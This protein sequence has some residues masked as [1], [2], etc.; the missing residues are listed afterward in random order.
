MTKNK[1]LKYLFSLEFG[2]NKRQIIMMG[3]FVLICLGFSA[4]TGGTFIT[5]RNLSNLSLQASATG[6]AAIGVVW[7]LVSGQIDLSIGSFIGFMGA[8]AAMLMVNHGWGSVETIAVVLAAGALLGAWQG[9]W[10]AYRRIP[11]FIVTLAGMQMFRGGCLM[12]TGGVTLSPMAN[13]YKGVGQAY[14]PGIFSTQ[15]GFVDSALYIGIILCVVLVFSELGRVRSRKKYKL[16]VAPMWFIAIKIVLTCAIVMFV[17]YILS[18]HMGLPVAAIVM[19][20]LAVSF[21]YISQNTR[22]GRYI[23][24]IGG[25]KEAARLSGINIRKNT[26]FIY[27]IMGV[28]CSISSIIY[29]ARLNAATAAAGQGMEMDA[30]A[31]AIIG[32]TST[33]G[34]EGSIFGAI[35]GAFIMSGIDNGMSIMNLPPQVQ[36]IVKGL[37]LLLAVWL[38]VSTRKSNK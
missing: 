34:G 17:S 30:I 29:T 38:D 11:S 21:S 23:Y 18:R 8:L 20:V 25:N 9:Y 2:K 26:F 15:K 32:G 10:I 31:S 37:V 13:I 3:V 22:F 16:E 1:G 36:Y 24:A 6:V 4:L 5:A 27:V 35:I 14:L 12:A 28:M 19:G 7:V 33:M